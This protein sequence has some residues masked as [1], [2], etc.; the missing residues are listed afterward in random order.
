MNVSTVKNAFIQ[1]NI[2]QCGTSLQTEGKKKKN[3]VRFLWAESPKMPF[4][5][6]LPFYSFC[7]SQGTW[8]LSTESNTDNTVN[9]GWHDTY[10]SLN[11]NLAAALENRKGNL[12]YIIVVT[13]PLRG[14]GLISY[15]I[16]RNQNIPFKSK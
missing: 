1:K 9:Q 16:S 5:A 4:I 3:S 2:Y 6:L 10:Q 14:E 7:C 13:L 8:D 15:Y 12:W 11:N